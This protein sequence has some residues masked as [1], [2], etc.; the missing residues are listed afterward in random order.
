[1][2]VVINKTSRTQTFLLPFPLKHKDHINMFNNSF[3]TSQKTIILPHYKQVN[4]SQTARHTVHT[5]A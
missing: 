1:M 4:Q 3:I 5:T 2:I